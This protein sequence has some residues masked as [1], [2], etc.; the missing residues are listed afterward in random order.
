MVESPKMS[1]NFIYSTGSSAGSA[2][3]LNATSTL[4]TQDFYFAIGS[5][6]D[7]YQTTFAGRDI[8]QRQQYFTSVTKNFTAAVQRS[9]ANRV[10]G[11]YRPGTAVFNA[12]AGGMNYVQE[13]SIDSQ[14]YVDVWQLVDYV[15]VYPDG[16]GCPPVFV[17]ETVQRYLQDSF[18]LVRASSLNYGV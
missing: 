17:N 2:V 11:I 7:E 1:F 5:D 14:N 3:L 13:K 15:P 4:Q 8:S 16:S 12:A 18:T 9:I 10:S 6:V